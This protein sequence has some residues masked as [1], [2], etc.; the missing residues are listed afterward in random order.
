MTA[1]VDE[2]LLERAPHDAS[3]PRV[4]PHRRARS[5]RICARPRRSGARAVQRHRHPSADRRRPGARPRSRPDLRDRR[6]RLRRAH[7]RLPE[8]V[9]RAHRARP[10]AG[11]GDRRQGRR[12]WPQRDRGDGRRR[13]RGDRRQPPDPRRAA[14]HRRHGDR[15]Q[16]LDL[17]HDRRPDEPY[18]L[19]GRPLHNQRLRQ[20]RAGVRHLRAGARRRGYLR[21]PGHVV[22]LPAPGPA[23]RRRHRPQGVRV[24]RGDGRLPDLLRAPDGLADPA[25]MLKVRRRARCRSSK[26][27]LAGPRLRD[28]YRSACCTTPSARSTRRPMRRRAA[29]PERSRG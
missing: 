27:D 26:F 16:Q 25:E 13:L 24:C 23:H 1:L 15:L 14:Q 2:E 7:H 12:P 5:R 4:T 17:W 18:H 22:R 8:L 3:L 20:R 6:H 28:R 10:R 11:R 19:R 21:R 9:D 29:R